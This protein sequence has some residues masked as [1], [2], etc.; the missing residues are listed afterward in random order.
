LKPRSIYI[1]FDA[2]EVSAFVVARSSI[3]NRLTSRIPIHGLVLPVLQEAGIYRR[4]TERHFGKLQD[5]LSRRNDYNGQISTEFALSRFLTPHLARTGL[6]LFMDCD[7]LVHADLCELF[8]HC[9]FDDPGK[10]VYCVKN[11]HRPA[12]QRK[13]DDQLQTHYERKNWSS[14]LM[15]D[16]DHSANKALTL[17]VVNNAPGLFLHGLRWLADADI[18]ELG[19][20]WNYLVGHTDANVEPKIIHH[21]DGSPCMTAFENAPFADDWRRELWLWAGA[22]VG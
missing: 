9:E 12:A 8:D 20:E 10:A 16:C 11:N 3:R 21:T 14:V 17:D 7:M 1:G 2:R 13:M 22:D 18:G 4:P 15:F 19:P 6:A 5:V